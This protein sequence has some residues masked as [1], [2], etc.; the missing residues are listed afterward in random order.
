[1]AGINDEDL[2]AARDAGYT[3]EQINDFLNPKP[4][5]TS[6]P[7]TLPD[8]A[9][10]AFRTPV[11]GGSTGPAMPEN[12][13]VDRSAENTALVAGGG[14]LAAGG[15]AK[16][17]A[18]YLAARKAI[19]KAGQVFRGPGATP[20]AGAAPGP[21]IQVPPNTGGVPRPQPNIGTPQQIMDTLRAPVPQTA[22]PPAAA[23]M[24][25]GAQPRPVVGGP[26][27]AEGATFIER[28]T[29]L[30]SRYAPVARGLTGSAAMLYSPSLNTG[31]D[32]QVRRM[33]EL[34]DQQRAQGLIQ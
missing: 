34:Q 5:V 10:T 14:A 9:T 19:E 4:I 23:E 3:D 31:E 33:R 15:A 11:V 8:T 16:L 25:A 20:T 7:T 18:E 12:P 21:Q 22:P 24:G 6:A 13:W 28:M 27:A 1:M 29:Q 17:G 32:E 2:Q 26:A 30:A